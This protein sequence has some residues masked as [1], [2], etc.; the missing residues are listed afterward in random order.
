MSSVTMAQLHSRWNPMTLLEGEFIL[1]SLRIAGLQIDRSAPAAPAQTAA[2]LILDNVLNTILPLPV[3]IRLNHARID[4][5]VLRIGG[6]EFSLLS[7]S[8]DGSLQ[9]QT[10]LIHELLVDSGEVSLGASI[11]LI[12]ENPYPI[13]A[14]IH[15][16]GSV[17]LNLAQMLNAR[18]DNLTTAVDLQ[19]SLEATAVPG[20]EQIVINSLTLVTQGSLDSLVLSANADISASSSAGI[21]V[22]TRLDARARLSGNLVVI[23]ELLL[24]TDSGALAVS[25]EL[26]WTQRIGAQGLTAALN[27]QLDDSAPDRYLENLPDNMSIRRLSSRGEL[28]LQ[29]SPEPGSLWQI[30]FTTPQTTALLNGYEL[31]GNG[32]FNVDGQRWQIND[33][34]LQNGNNRI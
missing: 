17:T 31:S 14:N 24:S 32:G 16:T 21:T 2:P 18:S 22:S 8:L 6:Q 19:H 20:L 29:Q 4:G 28:R 9:G 30:A 26:Q 10:L 11:E 23:D 27:Y 7:V 1:E 34:N 13:T 25:G 15:S 5:V 12:L 33:F 3:D